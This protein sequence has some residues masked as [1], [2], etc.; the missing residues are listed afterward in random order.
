MRWDI[1]LAYPDS[2]QGDDSL[3]AQERGRGWLDEARALMGRTLL[4]ATVAA[5]RE[6]RDAATEGDTERAAQDN[7]DRLA[8][9]IGRP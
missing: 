3:V 9:W 7:G 5:A 1:A 4:S 8:S 6:R 2:V